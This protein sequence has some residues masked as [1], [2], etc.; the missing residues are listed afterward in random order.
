MPFRFQ[1]F[2]VYKD[3]KDFIKEINIL[4][5][6]FPTIYQYDLGSQIRRAAISILL[7]LAEGSGR[8]SDKDFNRFINIS[9]GS[10]YEV[11][12]GLDI[13]LDNNLISKRNYQELYKKSESI[14]N[15]LGGLSKT[16]RSQNL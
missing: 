5:S 4:T 7:N 3:I 2:P 16:L 8:N 9:I 11:I 1:K 6:E 10:V 12:A 15:Q 14:K 13:A